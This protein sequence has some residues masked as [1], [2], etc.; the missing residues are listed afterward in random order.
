VRVAESLLALGIDAGGTYTDVVVYDVRNGRVLAKA[1]SPT[2]R[3]DP[4]E[5]ISRGLEFL[6]FDQWP[7]LAFVCLSTTFATNAIVENRT[8]R[9]GLILI[10]YPNFVS[11]Q[12]AFGPKRV[13][14]G[15][16][17]VEGNEHEPLSADELVAAAEDLIAQDVCAFAVSGMF[18]VV[19]PVHEL[20]AGRLLSENFSLP[21]VQGHHLSMSLNAAARAVTAGLNAG[22]L[23]LIDQLIRSV[24]HVLDGFGI[25]APLCLVKGDGTLVSADYGRERP[26]E[27]I[28]SGPAAS[29]AGG[30]HLAE[31]QSGKSMKDAIIVDIGG[32]TSD[33]GRVRSGRI[34]IARA[35]ARVG[36]SQTHVRAVDVRTLGLGGDSYVQ[37]NPERTLVIG[38]QRVVPLSV[39]AGDYPQVLNRLEKLA[40]DQATS[41]LFSPADFFMLIGSPESGRMNDRDRAIVEALRSGPVDRIELA[42]RVRAKYP[43][44]VATEELE[45][46]GHIM[47]SS[48]TPTDALVCCDRLALWPGDPA[49]VALR[50]YGRRLGCHA[51]DMAE[52]I[53]NEVYL[54]LACELMLQSMVSEKEKLTTP[55]DEKQLRVL[56][57]SILRRSIQNS[58]DRM[59]DVTLRLRLP[60][61]LIGAPAE[62]YATGLATMLG[63]EVTTVEHGEVASAVGA[64]VGKVVVRVSGEISVDA[65]GCFYAHLSDGRYEFVDLDSAKNFCREYLHRSA[66]EQLAQAGGQDGQ[67]RVELEDHYAELIGPAG[68]EKVYLRTELAA[69]ATGKPVAD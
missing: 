43:S 50:M 62:S 13:V 39:L 35:G 7:T 30:R 57:T 23:P 54:V 51:D 49:R 67:I 32:T 42:N 45:A 59:I 38:P 55:P 44:L 53:M 22:L 29:V 47:R 66:A 36:D 12:V 56:I 11:D 8:G 61:I 41:P 4:S 6:K 63:S 3:P 58:G 21:V 25:T 14:G 16:I 69:M 68:P 65:T 15:R 17:D 40:A 28:L 18:A 9:A 26:V 48:V 46:G 19:N 31:K 5:G 10:G 33:I 2:T 34:D 1:K 64:V 24:K 20:A 37:I 60:V 27:L 52:M